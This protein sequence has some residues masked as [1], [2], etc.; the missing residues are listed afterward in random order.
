MLHSCLMNYILLYC[1]YYNSINSIIA[2]G[3]AVSASMAHSVP[4]CSL[5]QMFGIAHPL[6]YC[7][8]DAGRGLIFSII[9]T[10]RGDM[11]RTLRVASQYLQSL[12]ITFDPGPKNQCDKPARILI[13][14]ILEH[15]YTSRRRATYSSACAAGPAACRVSRSCL[16]RGTSR[17][18]RSHTT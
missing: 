5:N 7:K 4:M 16:T 6:H 8:A 2:A 10:W 12:P 13:S 14:T 17:K 15:S 18:R 11:T 1:A 9:E 3:S